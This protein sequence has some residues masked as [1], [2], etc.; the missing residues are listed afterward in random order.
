MNQALKTHPREEEVELR[1]K[2]LRLKEAYLR[3]REGDTA[4]AVRLVNTL[5]LDREVL[6]LYEEADMNCEKVSVLKLKLST[7]LE[8]V[9][10]ESPSLAAVL[11]TFQQLFYAELQV[12]SLGAASKHNLNTLRGEV[13]ILHEDHLQVANQFKRAQSGQ[14]AMLQGIQSQRLEAATHRGLTSLRVELKALHEQ[15]LQTREEA[16]RVQRFIEQSQNA[17]VATQKVLSSL[18]GQPVVLSNDLAQVSTQC[19]RAYQP[20]RQRSEVSK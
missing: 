4:T 2:R 14:E 17:E 12:L 19:N 9:G 18:R 5:P 11:D 10:R 13:G 8:L 1:L 3:L 6:E 20:T 7:A 16:K 15:A